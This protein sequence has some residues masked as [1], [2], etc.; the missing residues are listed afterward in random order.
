QDLDPEPIQ[1][2]S[3]LTIYPERKGMGFKLQLAALAHSEM[4]KC[5]LHQQIF[6]RERF[7]ILTIIGMAANVWS[8]RASRSPPS[9]DTGISIRTTNPALALKRWQ[10][11]EYWSLMTNRTAPLSQ[12]IC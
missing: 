10:D 4:E 5:F 1:D 6:R 12:V 8:R 3:A 7:E 9:H 2:L 11:C